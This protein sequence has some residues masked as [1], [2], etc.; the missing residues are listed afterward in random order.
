M[1]DNEVE[2]EVE[3]EVEGR[4]WLGPFFVLWMYIVN[5]NNPILK[6]SCHHLNFLLNYNHRLGLSQNISNIHLSNFILDSNP[7]T[8]M[9][10]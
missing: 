2:V 1:E 7:P 5:P 10:A 3:V 8:S 4:L 9:S 6:V